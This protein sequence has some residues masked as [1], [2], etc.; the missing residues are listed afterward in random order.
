[1]ALCP[2]FSLDELGIPRQQFWGAIGILTHDDSPSSH[3]AYEDPSALHP[4]EPALQPRQPHRKQFQV[5][6]FFHLVEEFLP[7]LDLIRPIETLE[8]KWFPGPRL[9][10]S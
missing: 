2:H 7:D 8:S 3:D 6:H 1:E 10:G 9:H 4:Q 5:G